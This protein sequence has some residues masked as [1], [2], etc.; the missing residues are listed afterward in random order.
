MS[1][2][3]TEQES[4]DLKRI[5]MLLETKHGDLNKL[6]YFDLERLRTLVRKALILANYQEYCCEILEHV[7]DCL[8]NKKEC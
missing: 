4:R 3:L 6:S 8:E 7:A 5:I 1:Y 2:H